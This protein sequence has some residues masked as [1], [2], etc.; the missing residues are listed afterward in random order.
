MVELYYTILGV[1]HNATLSEIK[2][3][4]RARAK[5]LHP[6]INKSHDAHQQFILLN[7]A[8]EYLI[9]ARTGKI[10]DNNSTST[11]RYK[12]YERWQDNEAARARHRAEY[13]ANKKYNEFAD[14]EHYKKMTEVNENILRVS[15]FVLITTLISLPIVLIMT[16]GSIRFWTTLILVFV[17]LM[18]TVDIVRKK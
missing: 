17:T 5:E 3:A 4:F 1:S 12:T 10:F 8:Y 2:K 14:S 13:Y 18:F 16:S 15:M 11:R 6:D 9:N 7:E